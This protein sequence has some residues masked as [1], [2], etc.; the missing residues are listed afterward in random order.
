LPCG[1]GM[2]VTPPLSSSVVPAF[3]SC[4]LCSQEVER[5]KGREVGDRKSLCK[6]SFHMSFRGAAGDDE[7][8]SGPGNIQGEIPRC[9]RN[10]T[11]NQ[12]FTQAP[13]AGHK[14]RAAFRKAADGPP[15]NR[16][17][18]VIPAKAGIHR[19]DTGSPLPRGRRW[20]SKSREQSQ[21]VYENK[22]QGQSVAELDSTDRRFCGLR[23]FRRCRDEPR[24]ANTVVRAARI[25]GNKARMYMKTNDKYKKSLNHSTVARRYAVVGVPPRFCGSAGAD[26]FGMPVPFTGRGGSPT[27]AISALRLPTGEGLW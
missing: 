11:L 22:A 7:S 9:A 14:A 16:A 2:P 8:R 25:R 23:L 18:V 21:N 15:E 4:L 26:R 27:A 6:S 20:F 24:T 5:S 13:K 3:G 10:D 1:S 12:V 17:P 19:T